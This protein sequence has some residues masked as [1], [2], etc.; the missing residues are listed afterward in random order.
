MLQKGKIYDQTV[1]TY[2]VAF[3]DKDLYFKGSN[4]GDAVEFIIDPITYRQPDGTQ[5]TLNTTE[6]AACCNLAG[7]IPEMYQIQEQWKPD[8]TGSGYYT[9]KFSLLVP[10]GFTESYGSQ[11]Q[12]G[13]YYTI[14]NGVKKGQMIC[15]P[16]H[17]LAFPP[18]AIAFI[19][20]NDNVHQRKP[21]LPGACADCRSY[22]H[23]RGSPK[24]SYKGFCMT[25]LEYLPDLPEQGYKHACTAG[26]PYA[27][28]FKGEARKGKGGKGGKGKSKPC[29]ATAEQKDMM[30]AT[31]AHLAKMEE[32][33][34]LAFKK[35]KAEKDLEG[36]NLAS[37][38]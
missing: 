3:Q 35:R 30:K 2:N 11:E 29:R 5:V 16:M 27:G 24:C 9:G 23:K 34:R 20:P 37:D 15:K 12:S 1:A 6:I 4:K 10:S 25:C 8:N 18:R 38:L 21:F 26:I 22:S 28:A 17:K 33:R 32:Q 31:A 36:L 19:D 7:T 13:E 14:K